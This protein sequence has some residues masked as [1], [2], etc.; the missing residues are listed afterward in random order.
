MEISMKM[1]RGIKG[2]L[3][4]RFSHQKYIQYYID[5]FKFEKEELE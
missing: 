3:K 2:G 5:G 4:K 1:S